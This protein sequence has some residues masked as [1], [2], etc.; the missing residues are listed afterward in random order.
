MRA[1]ALRNRERIVAAARDLVARDGADVTMEALARRA[2]VAVGTLYR[3]FPT[4][5]DLVAAVVEESIE[6]IAGLAELAA[7]HVRDG[8]APGD[9]VAALF[10]A[11]AE[12]YASDRAVKQAAA[13]LGL[14][15]D[16]HVTT[17]APDTAAGR[18]TTS[19][20][21]VLSA[22]Q[23]AGQVDLSLTLEDLVMLLTQV[24]DGPAGGAQDRYVDI[25]LAGLRRQPH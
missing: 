2:G 24:P 17:A 9:E 13:G 7:E 12:R 4:K 1:D 16:D 11:V 21:Y 18:A 3:H 25:V 8:S 22:A 5:Q 15:V 10:R 6:H 14:P 23:E 20:G 19:I